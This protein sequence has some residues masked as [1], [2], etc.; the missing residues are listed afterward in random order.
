[1]KL[2]IER[3]SVS[4]SLLGTTERRGQQVGAEGTSDPE[5]GKTAADWY[6]NML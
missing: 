5:G 3:L 1:M 2:I 6:E 4:V